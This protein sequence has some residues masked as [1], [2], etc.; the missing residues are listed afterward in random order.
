MVIG[1]KIKV[2][3]TSS[4]DYGEEFVVGKGDVKDIF[5]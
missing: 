3:D 1:H 5:V 4:N 2:T